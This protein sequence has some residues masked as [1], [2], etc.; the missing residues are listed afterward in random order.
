MKRQQKIQT[1]NSG[2]QKMQLGTTALSSISSISSGCHL[3][4]FNIGH[5][6]VLNTKMMNSLYFAPNKQSAC[7][8]CGFLV[9][10]LLR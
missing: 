1:K 3:H 7:D 8:I 6:T 9:F 2:R 5:L 10:G 4:R